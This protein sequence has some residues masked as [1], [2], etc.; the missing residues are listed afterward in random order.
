[1]NFSPTT[2]KALKG[3]G[4]ALAGTGALFGA[5]TIGYRTGAERMG[6]SM[7]TAFSHHNAIENEAIADNIAQQFMIANQA[8]NEQLAKFHYNRGL[9]SQGVEKK[10][11]LLDTL[12]GMV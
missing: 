2:V 3:A 8:E 7:A 10:S 4:I 11:S 5:G 9:A 12:A 6:A 1:M